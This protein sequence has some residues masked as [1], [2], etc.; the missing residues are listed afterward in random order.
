MHFQ[1]GIHKL[2]DYKSEYGD[3]LVPKNYETLDGFKLGNWVRHKR[4]AK[5]KGTLCNDQIKIDQRT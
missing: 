3:M 1:Q 4:K 2:R 5:S